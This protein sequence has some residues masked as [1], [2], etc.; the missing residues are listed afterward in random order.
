M[1]RSINCRLIKPLLIGVILLFGCE[2][3]PHL[4][5]Q[6]ILQFGTV[7]DVS[8]VHHDLA[9][10]EQALIEIEQL[11]SA[12]RASWHAWEDSELSRFNLALG[13]SGAVTVP[14]SLLELIT[15]SQRYYLISNR[16]FN[17]ALGKL[18]A[19]YG[20]HGQAD[21]DED[22]IKIIQ[23]DLPTM[24]DLEIQN[25]L[26]ISRNPHLQLDFGG[27]AKGYA[28]GLIASHLDRQGFEHYLINAGGDL[29]TSGNRL[30]KAWRIGVKN[31]FEPGAIASIGLLGKQALFTS[32]N[33]QRFY[34]NKNETVHHI[35]DPRSGEP[36]KHISSAT[37]LTSDPVL[38]DVAATTLMID[39]L[40]NYRSLA[41]SLGIEDY[42]II[43]D[44]QRIT[45]SGSL[46]GKIELAAGLV[47]TIV[48]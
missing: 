7:I 17:P 33:Y 36:S 27:I 43:D 34:R 24:A 19:A 45:I 23:Q 8:L 48:E 42:M 25:R 26:A 38:A 20:F 4:V 10:A 28:V 30:G 9:K 22:L 21:L 16:L 40:N 18:I 46:A 11:L 31:P 47:V 41:G 3:Q 15:L 29:I 39:G 14:A 2:Q 35:I 13:N 37:V 5:E 32:G 44:Q 1:Y 6:R 12:Y